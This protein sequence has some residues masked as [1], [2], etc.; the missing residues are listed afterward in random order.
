MAQRP[1]RRERRGRR[2]DAEDRPREPEHEYYSD[3]RGAT[4]YI[5]TNSGGRNFRLVTA[6]VSA[7]RKENW[8]EVVAHRDDVML[9]DV[10]VFRDFVALYERDGSGLGFYEVGGPH[11]V[12]CPRHGRPSRLLDFEELPAVLRPAFASFV[13][14]LSAEFHAAAKRVQV[15]IPVNHAAYDAARWLDFYREG[16]DYIL[17]LNAQGFPVSRQPVAGAMVVYGGS[18]GPFGH[19][20]TV[21]AVEADRYEVIEQNFLDFSPTIQPHWQTFVLRS[22]AWPDPAVVG[23]VVAPA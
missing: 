20:A 15:D 7:P 3:A 4:L 23:F 21:R 19:I 6:Q 9:Q 17:E 22:I 16:L 18:Y 1:A 8:K 5:R 12:P 11:S 14:E 13:A 10:E 2:G